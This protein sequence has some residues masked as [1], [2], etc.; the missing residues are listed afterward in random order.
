MYFSKSGWPRLY[1][2]LDCNFLKP[3]K[4]NHFDTWSF[5][6]HE[7]QHLKICA[8]LSNIPVPSLGATNHMYPCIS[9]C[10]MPSSF[11]QRKQL[12]PFIVGAKFPSSESLDKQQTLFRRQEQR[13]TMD[14]LK[15]ESSIPTV[16]VFFHS[17]PIHSTEY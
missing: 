13:A 1:L 2:H 6:V 16:S 12:G 10:H 7:L 8:G 17:K 14:F 3:H 11:L 5:G 4:Q 15:L 9:Q